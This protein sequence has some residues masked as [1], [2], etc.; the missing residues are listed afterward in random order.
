MKEK[1]KGW[2]FIVAVLVILLLVSIVIAAFLGLFIETT[3]ILDG[4]IAKIAI[5][6]PIVVSDGG[7]FSK[8]TTVD[9]IKKLIEKANKSDVKAIIFEINSPGG[10]AVAS[11][12]LAQAVKNVNKTT[13][14]VIREVGASGAYWAASATDHVIA[15]RMSIT[16][17]IGVRGS[18]LEFAGLLKEYNVTYRGL[19]AGKYKDIG[20]PYKQLSREEEM[21]LQEV[22]DELHDVFIG[23]VAENRG[24]SREDVE[25]LATGMFYTG[26]RAKEL[27]LVDELGGLEE[28][29]RYIE[30]K[31]NITASVSE[32]KKPKSFFERLQESSYEKSFFVGKGIG[33]EIVSEGNLQ[34][35]T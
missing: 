14:A 15:N 16:G 20:S 5:T 2:G 30:Q 22:L 6:G 31:Y 34:I 9:D 1:G 19:T 33:S 35:T 11:D 13:V 10:S 32:Y 12:E 4:N 27:G 28:A 26:K 25:K 3:P 17:S 24:M 29:K 21:M 7:F 23:S 18:Y 8:P